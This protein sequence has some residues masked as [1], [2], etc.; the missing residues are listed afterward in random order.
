MTSINRALITGVN[1]Q[2][3][4]YLAESLL[5]EGVEVHGVGS[6]KESRNPI[7]QN[8]VIF[9]KT[10]ISDENDISKLLFEVHPEVIYHF[11]AQSS[12]LNSLDN[13]SG[14]L[15]TNVLNSITL[16]RSILNST[17]NS[18]IILAGS[19]EMF[20]SN[21]LQ[22]WDI[23]TSLNPINPY[24]VSKAAIFLISD[25]YRKIGLNLATAILFN[26]ESRRRPKHFLTRKVIDS[27]IEVSK[28]RAPAITIGN[29]SLIRD[30][31]YAPEYVEAMKRMS[32]LDI[33]EDF[34]ICT[35]KPISI[36][37]FASTALHYL[38]ISN[39]ID[40]IISDPSLIRRNEAEK[41]VGAPERA[42]EKLGWTAEFYGKSL[43]ELL[44]SQA[45]LEQEST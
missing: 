39:P 43:V 29:L 2:D 33:L 16:L 45:L 30:F 10:S 19:S 13:I 35:G 44:T 42:T 31:G 8:D 23:G 25:L 22:P 28:G 36:F 26:H 27:A 11:A 1:G 4:T 5:A 7:L 14:T 12:V 15:E 24:G 6:P 21:S 3:G 17:P 37:D 9:H 34:V 38:G 18:R 20:D 40:Y 32:T 41:I